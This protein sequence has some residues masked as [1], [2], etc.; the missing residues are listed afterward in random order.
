MANILPAA[1]RLYNQRAT[2][3]AGA[4][5]LISPAAIAPAE[6]AISK[7]LRE[8]LKDLTPV[9]HAFANSYREHQTAKVDDELLRVEQEFDQWKHDYTQ[10]NQGKDAEKAAAEFA[11]KH[12]E[13]KREAIRRLDGES[14]EIFEGLLEKR[15]D[16]A[17]VLATRQGLAYQEQQDRIWKA[18]Q[19]ESQLA[20][21]YR[22]VQENPDNWD[23]INTEA[24]NV[25]ASW[26]AKNPGQDPTATILKLEDGIA[27]NRVDVLLA[28]EKFDEAEAA[29]GTGLLRDPRLYRGGQICEDLNNPLNIKKPGHNGSSREAFE[30]FKT[31]EDGIRAAGN[32][33]QRYQK[34]GLDTAAKII[35]TWAPK[36]ENNTEKY[37]ADVSSA[38]GIKPDQKLDLD[39]PEVRARLIRAMGQSEGRAI[40]KFSLDRI[41]SALLENGGKAEKMNLPPMAGGMPPLIAAQTSQRIKAQREAT[42]R[43]AEAQERASLAGIQYDIENA[44]AAYERGAE[45]DFP[46]DEKDII[47]LYGEGRAARVIEQIKTASVYS[48]DLNAIRAMTAEQQNALLKA[49][50]PQAGDDHYKVRAQYHDMLA[51]RIHQDQE[52]RKKDPAGYIFAQSPAMQEA[53]GALIVDPGQQNFEMYMRQRAEAQAALGIPQ[54]KI[55]PEAISAAIAGRLNTSE[56]PLADVNNLRQMA[57]SAWPELR[58]EI[59]PKGSAHLSIICNGSMSETDAANLMETKSIPKFRESA[60]DTLGIV[61]KDFEEGMRGELEDTLAAYY[62]TGNVD[63]ANS[64][65]D[66]GVDLAL[67]NMLKGKMG[68]NEAIKKA[69]ASVRG[70]GEVVK[71]PSGTY[72]R[73]PQYDANDASTILRGLNAWID[74]LKPDDILFY[75]KEGVTAEAQMDYLKYNLKNNI[76]VANDDD[77]QHVFITLANHPVCDK[78]GQPIRLSLP[79]LLKLGL[80]N[81]KDS[82]YEDILN[83]VGIMQDLSGEL[84]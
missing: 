80:E 53:A 31:P 18:S 27:R 59:L 68:K 81:N 64:L 84:F 12:D 57:G 58:Q 16:Q 61:V 36:K 33:L 47:K 37:I 7:V 46:V 62:S 78:N 40:S 10:A 9:V 17:G 34:R 26:Q 66:N 11:A 79:D 63:F 42:A 71:S 49:R 30:Y 38:M 75:P 20:S 2:G 35:S 70:K 44:L 8:R 67:Q 24:Q 15:L 72:W 65:L 19:W 45:M 5:R 82:P 29:L 83:Q 21:F 41:K 60:R 74:N 3:G 43:K 52:L 77:E 76:S 23:L 22:L 48:Q 69:A 55:F 1:Q 39:D 51:Q 73:I 6:S 28:Q 13:L 54:A 32:L 4:P 50:M 56:H 25:I 14:D